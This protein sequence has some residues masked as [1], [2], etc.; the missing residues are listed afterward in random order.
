MGS[1]PCW[2]YE[3]EVYRRHDQFRVR[4]KQRIGHDIYLQLRFNDR[5]VRPGRPSGERRM[6]S[7]AVRTAINCCH[8][9][10][11]PKQGKLAFKVTSPPSKSDIRPPIQRSD[12]PPRLRESVATDSHTP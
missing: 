6:F 9:L 2:N 11:P 5:P 10:T 12:P 8:K 7:G 4:R 1:R 3:R